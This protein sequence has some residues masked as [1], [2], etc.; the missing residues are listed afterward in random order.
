MTETVA[1]MPRVENSAGKISHGLSYCNSVGN[2]C[3]QLFRS[4]FGI[5]PIGHSRQLN[6]VKLTLLFSMPINQL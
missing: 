4:P 3:S 2:I 6:N 1:K 5:L